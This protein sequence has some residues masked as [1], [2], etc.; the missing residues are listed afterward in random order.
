DSH[1][2]DG[3]EVTGNYFKV[4]GVRPELGRFFL[5]EE[6]AGPGS[7]PAVVIGYDYWQRKYGGDRDVVGR[8]ILVDGHDYSIVGVA[9]DGFR[10]IDPGVVDLWIPF[11]HDTKLGHGK[12]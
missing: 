9:P 10:G 6:D 11:A 1:S 5:D 12:D 2:A 4:L 3:M 8:N 7:P